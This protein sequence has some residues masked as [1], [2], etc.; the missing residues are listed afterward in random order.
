MGNVFHIQRFSLY[1]GP[2]VRT[3]VFL[4]GCPLRCV[5]CHN[6]EGLSPQYQI[7]YN[8]SKCIGCM[9]C[10]DACA[11]GCHVAHGQAHIYHHDLCN[12]CGKC[13][14]VCCSGALSL[15]GRDFTP[16]EVMAQVLRD[17]EVYTTSGGG[18]TLSGG[19][20]FAQADFTIALLQLAKDH[21]LHTCVETSGYA[22]P[23]SLT[24][25]AKYTDLFLYDYKVT[26]DALH[27][28]L[29]GVS[30]KKILDN[31]SLLNDLGANVILRCPVIPGC[32]DEDSHIQAIGKLAA[33]HS[34]IQ[35]VHLE[36]YH[37][38]GIDKAAQLGT[39][40]SFET[41]PPDGDTMEQYRKAIENIS[42][43]PVHIS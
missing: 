4:K 18:L 20:P 7:Q 13:A 36:P 40:P 1:D 6:P 11:S 9:D 3:V 31:L 26:D 23:Q 43:K 16:Q 37:R 2:G 29:C 33:S 28:K 17:Q 19:E 42:Q 32:N 38:L 27:Q 5:W 14:E 39:L 41:V 35:Q 34:C 24:Q 10:V 8:A 15:C 25:A 30:N 12:A 22:N 21:D